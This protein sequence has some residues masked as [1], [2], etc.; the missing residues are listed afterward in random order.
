MAFSRVARWGPAGNT[1]SMWSPGLEWPLSLLAQ[2]TPPQAPGVNMITVVL[3]E[4]AAASLLLLHGLLW[5]SSLPCSDLLSW[6]PLF[7]CWPAFLLWP[8]WWVPIG[9]S[10]CHGNPQVMGSLGKHLSSWI[11]TQ[12]TGVF[13]LEETPIPKPRQA[14][15]HLLAFLFNPFKGTAKE[16]VT[17]LSGGEHFQPFSCFSSFLTEQKA[18]I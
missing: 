8:P 10:A 11:A 9:R 3:L 7:H 4:S 16:G 15:P 1:Q 17:Q 2:Y 18:R 13:P 6:L 5:Q 12:W 14:A